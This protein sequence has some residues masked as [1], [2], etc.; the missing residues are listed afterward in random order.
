MA[1]LVAARKES[2]LQQ[3]KIITLDTR[4]KAL[5]ADTRDSQERERALRAEIDNLRTEKRGLELEHE[6]SAAPE[7]I[8][9]VSVAQLRQ[10][11]QQKAETS[12]EKDAEIGLLQSER[13]DIE[14]A[15]DRVVAAISGD[16]VQRTATSIVRT[17]SDLHLAERERRRLAAEADAGRMKDCER[18]IQEERR[19]LV[20]L[21]DSLIVAQT[22]KEEK[23]G[24]MPKT[25]LSLRYAENEQWRSVDADQAPATSEG[26]HERSLVVVG[27][28]PEVPARAAAKT[29]NADATTM[30]GSRT[31]DGA[32]NKSSL[33]A[34]NRSA[35]QQRLM[36]LKSSFAGD[37]SHKK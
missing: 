19:R 32:E 23:A 27:D 17:L 20:E 28:S 37:N 15:L 5:S 25:S 13:R 24:E 29:K 34:M 30:R 2:Q 4:Y 14:A 26:R 33:V 22:K 21:E 35:L 10:Q 1:N 3:Q 12:P 18:R 9:P 8:K 31:S 36:Q 6:N 11:Q 7:L 16:K